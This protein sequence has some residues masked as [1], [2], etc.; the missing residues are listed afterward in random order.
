MKAEAHSAALLEMLSLRD[1]VAATL[2][3]PARA[4]TFRR[5]VALVRKSWDRL[6]PHK[7]EECAHIMYSKLRQEDPSVGD[8]FDKQLDWTAQERI[9]TVMIGNLVSRLEDP[10]PNGLVDTLV[11][12]GKRHQELGVTPKQ[13]TCMQRA[14]LATL[15]E[16]LG[17]EWTNEYSEAWAS[18]FHFITHTMIKAAQEPGPSPSSSSNA[19]MDKELGGACPM[20]FVVKNK[21]LA[22][23]KDPVSTD[24]HA[25]QRHHLPTGNSAKIEEESS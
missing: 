1:Y 7:L 4:Q 25:L 2:E 23:A 16:L 3:D 24:G 6:K 21:Y 17:D 19:S 9:F 13:Y 8:V 14:I 11:R 20:P 18:V 12:L 10:N 15:E 22:V 5:H